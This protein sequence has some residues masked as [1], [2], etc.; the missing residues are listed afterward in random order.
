MPLKETGLI[1][2]DIGFHRVRAVTQ[3]TGAAPNG[4]DIPVPLAGMAA[5]QQ[6]PVAKVNR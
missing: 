1:Q 5:L 4:T 3:F 6:F 2:H